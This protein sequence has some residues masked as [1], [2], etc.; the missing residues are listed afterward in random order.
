MI[1][2]QKAEINQKKVNKNCEAAEICILHKIGKAVRFRLAFCS[3]TDGW[4]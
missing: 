2:L 4:T 1:G 3:W